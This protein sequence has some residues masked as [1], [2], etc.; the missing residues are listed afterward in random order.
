METANETLQWIL[1]LYAIWAIYQLGCAIQSL[2]E[3]SKSQ[4]E[5]IA[6]LRERIDF[7]TFK[8]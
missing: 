7:L 3:V 2:L 1:I 8:K 6:S 4:N 5:I